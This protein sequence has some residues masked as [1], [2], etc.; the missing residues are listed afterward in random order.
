[1]FTTLDEYTPDLKLI[2][3]DP[4]DDRAVTTCM[5]YSL[6][7]NEIAVGNY[8]GEVLLYSIVESKG[9]YFCDLKLI[10]NFQDEKLV[11]GVQCGEHLYMLS[12]VKIKWADFDEVCRK[13]SKRHPE[14]MDSIM[15]LMAY[16]GGRRLALGN[17][18]L[19]IIPGS[20]EVRACS[21]RILDTVDEIAS[22]D[23]NM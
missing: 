12:L 17:K 14:S 8:R 21:F 5:A 19:K 18:T 6:R 9:R 1:M 7:T 20:P 15:N 16:V 10:Y 22:S 13:G 11:T 4:E 3:E 23:A 2:L